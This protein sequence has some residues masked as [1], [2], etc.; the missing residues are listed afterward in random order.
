MP[1]WSVLNKAGVMVFLMTLPAGAIAAFFG[2]EMLR[3]NVLL[4]AVYLALFLAIGALI[5]LMRIHTNAEL[6]RNSRA[7]AGKWAPFLRKSVL[8]PALWLGGLGALT[9]IVMLIGVGMPVL[10]AAPLALV[11][12]FAPALCFM[13]AWAFGEVAD[14]LLP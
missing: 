11:G 8:P 4:W 2:P 12:S 1:R 9:A 3:A 7:A 6:A 5:F 10:R 14:L 13:C